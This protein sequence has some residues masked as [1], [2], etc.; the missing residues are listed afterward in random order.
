M[1]SPRPRLGPKSG[2]PAQTREKPQNAQKAHFGKNPTRCTPRG[3]LLLSR[4]LSCPCPNPRAGRAA[5]KRAAACAVWWNPISGLSPSLLSGVQVF[6]LKL[7]DEKRPDLRRKLWRS[8]FSGDTLP[9]RFWGWWGGEFITPPPPTV[10]KD[11]PRRA[12]KSSRKRDEFFRNRPVCYLSLLASLGGRFKKSRRDSFRDAFFHRPL[13]F[14]GVF[15]A[16][17]GTVLFPVEETA[18][19][20]R[21]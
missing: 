20:F 1:P 13:C 21:G 4:P 14:L 7:G 17:N 19:I 18:R 10:P 9:G 5:A 8:D 16:R 6:R 3:A 11:R 12:S 15:E 2:K